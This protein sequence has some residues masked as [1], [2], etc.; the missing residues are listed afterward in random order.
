MTY[1]PL[2]RFVSRSVR[3]TGVG[4]SVAGGLSPALGPPFVCVKVIICSG[5]SYIIWEEGKSW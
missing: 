1:V 3:I 2:I 4:T 5:I